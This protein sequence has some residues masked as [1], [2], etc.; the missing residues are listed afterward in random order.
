MES[1]NR[2]VLVLV[3]CW[4]LMCAEQLSKEAFQCNYSCWSEHSLLVSPTV[5]E[6]FHIGTAER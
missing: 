2:G 3:I 5:E 4:I 6:G 1:R